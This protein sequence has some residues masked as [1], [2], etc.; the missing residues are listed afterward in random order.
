MESTFAFV[1][2]Q[3]RSIS[4]AQLLACEIVFLAYISKA[5]Y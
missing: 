4:F 2:G 3:S 5:E 1:F